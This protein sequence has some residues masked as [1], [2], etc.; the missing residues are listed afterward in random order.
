MD[1]CVTEHDSH[2]DED[3]GTT[4]GFKTFATVPAKSAALR[5]TCGD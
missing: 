4:K 1:G 3:A 2:H 5:V